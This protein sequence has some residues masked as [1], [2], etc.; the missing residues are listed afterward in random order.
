MNVFAILLFFWIRNEI[1]YFKKRQPLRILEFSGKFSYSLYLCHKVFIFFIG[2]VFPLTLYTYFPV[3]L[4]TLGA[5]YLFY[6]AVE[7]PGH[8]LSRKAAKW[9]QARSL[10]PQYK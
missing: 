3:M 5:S 6:L 9:I 7:R 10:N 4:L 8:L 1:L 2:L